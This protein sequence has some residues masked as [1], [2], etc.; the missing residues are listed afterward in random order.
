MTPL[1]PVHRNGHEWLFSRFA[2]RS[3]RVPRST[4]EFR[5]V[6]RST[7]GRTPFEPPTR[8]GI[9][10]GNASV[11]GQDIV[12]IAVDI[13]AR[14][15]TLAEPGEIVVSRTV[16]GLIAGS[17]IHLVDHGEHA[18]SGISEPWRIYGAGATATP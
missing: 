10:T 16:K 1:L 18:L 3:T 6:G 5:R 12:G 15:T 17:G 8:V 14:I 9:H 11:G 2:R 4:D 13:A 7:T